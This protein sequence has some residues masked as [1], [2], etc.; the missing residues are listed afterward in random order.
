MEF[1]FVTVKN[2]LSDNSVI[3]EVR[4]HG[5]EGRLASAA[6][7]AEAKELE[8]NLNLAVTDWSERTTDNTVDA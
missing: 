6:T 8:M 4:Q 5:A 2:V 7:E 3:W 1:P